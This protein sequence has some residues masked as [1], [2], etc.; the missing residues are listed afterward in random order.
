MKN[1]GTQTLET[2][3]LILR[4]WDKGDARAMYENYAS[5]PQVTKFM[6]WPRHENIETSEYI[7][8][9]WG[10]SYSKDNYYEWAI[11]PKDMNEPIGS[12]GAVRVDEDLSLVHVGYCIGSKWWHRGITSEAFAAVINFFFDEVGVER[13]EAQHDPRNPHSGGVMKKC[14]LKYEGTLRKTYRNNQ[15]ICDASYYG[16]LKTERE[17]NEELS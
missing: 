2:E 10:N 6:S 16:L 12:I 4:R 14:G 11:V 3:R 1:I 7:V 17:T 5:D 15:G 8:S 9:D 13:I